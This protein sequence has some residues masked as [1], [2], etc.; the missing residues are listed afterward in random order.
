MKKINFISVIIFSLLITGCGVAQEQAY[1]MTEVDEIEV[2]ILPPS[3]VMQ[4][5]S[6]ADSYFSENNNLFSPLFRYLKDNEL[7]MT[8]PVEADIENPKMRFFIETSKADINYKSNNQ[9]EILEIPARKV[10]SIG[11]RGSYTEANFQEGK[12]KLEKWLNENEEY[13][14]NGKAYAVYWNAPFVPGFLKKSEVHI[15]VKKVN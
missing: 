1:K 14:P 2:K 5:S 10:V 13:V 12:A 15:P 4:S 11:I 8:T 9:V 7:A 3:K 6:E